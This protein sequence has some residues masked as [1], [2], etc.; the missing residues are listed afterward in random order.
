MRVVVLPS[1]PPADSVVTDVDIIIIIIIICITIVN[2]YYCI[3][4]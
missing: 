4:H 2:F 1:S 3:F